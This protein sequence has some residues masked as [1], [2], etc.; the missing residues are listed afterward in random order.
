MSASDAKFQ[1]NR[2]RPPHSDADHARAC[3]DSN[4]HVHDDDNA[5]ADTY[6]DNTHT[7]HADADSYAYNADSYARAY[8][9]DAYTNAH[10]DADIHANTNTHANTHAHAHSDFNAYGNAN[11]NEVAYSHAHACDRHHHP[12]G[13]SRWRRRVGPVHLPL[14]VVGDVGPRRDFRRES[15]QG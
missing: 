14:D 7:H 8:N 4:A 1:R 2:D 9:A 15:M 13:A 12:I 3:N 5:Y 10:S 6:A 11:S